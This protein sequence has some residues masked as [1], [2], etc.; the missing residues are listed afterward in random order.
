M[1]KLTRLDRGQDWSHTGELGIEVAR[2][3]RALDLGHERRV[4][5]LVVDVLPVD[6]PKER[7]AHHLLCVGWAAAQTLVGLPR[8]QLLQNRHRVPRHVDRIE[9]LVGENGVINF[10]LVLSSERGLLKKHLVNEDTE[11]PPID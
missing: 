9:R 10:V 4:D 2:I 3:R 11:R 8:Q 5:A 7:L 6:V 1:A